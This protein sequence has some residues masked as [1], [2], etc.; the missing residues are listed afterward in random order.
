[1]KVAFGAFVFDSDT[2]E[3]LEE[4]RRVHLSPKAFDML[5]ILLEA[6]PKVV[7]K[8]ELQDR[9]WGP[10]TIVGDA[11]L[12]VVVAEIRHVLGD[13]SRDAKFVRTVH[14][15]GYA[16]SGPVVDLPG[17][18]TVD[19]AR[20]S[21]R[22]WLVWE[23]RTFPL[24]N[25]DNV[26]GRDPRCDVWIDASGVSRRHAVIRVRPEGV[27][28]EDLGSSNG[29]FIAGRPIAAPLPLADGDSIEM[30]SVSLAFRAWSDE[31]PPATERIRRRVNRRG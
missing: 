31:R 25:G 23:G 24:A 4:G 2:R 10:D 19:G 28:I 21:A 16:F 17:S 27:T 22:C 14:R 26:V 1:M 13:D 18:T 6:R 12:T 30:G 20:Q 8:G 3:L 9:I 7:P 11:S 15:V 29:T 5:R